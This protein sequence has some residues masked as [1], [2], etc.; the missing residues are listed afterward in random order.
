MKVLGEV[1]I[2]IIRHISWEIF[3]QEN[4]G[5]QVKNSLVFF[6]HIDLKGLVQPNCSNSWQ[7][8]NCIIFFKK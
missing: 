3:I 1:L 5:Y 8:F 4:R 6:I 7:C 2:Y